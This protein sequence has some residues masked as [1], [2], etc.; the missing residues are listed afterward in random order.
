MLTDGHEEA[1]SRFSLFFTK[2]INV[3]A[4][5]LRKSSGPDLAHAPEVVSFCP[6]SCPSVLAT[7]RSPFSCNFLLRKSN[8][9]AIKY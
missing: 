3:A 7:Y 6:S 9:R 5:G 8:D 1:N 2:T 4:L